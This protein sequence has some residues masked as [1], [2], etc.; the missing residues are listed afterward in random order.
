MAPG[1]QRKRVPYLKDVLRKQPKL[2]PAHAG[3][4]RAYVFSGQFAAAIPEL[5]AA[6]PIDE[7][8]SLRYEL[9]KAYRATGQPELAN[10]M[11]EQYQE[12]QKADREEKQKLEQEMQITAP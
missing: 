8:G 4:G 12:W 3:L 9:A 1:M 5:S 6:L 10:K 11:I 2:L 7:D